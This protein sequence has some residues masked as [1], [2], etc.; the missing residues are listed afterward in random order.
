VVKELS[1]GVAKLAV[2]VKDSKGKPISVFVQVSK[3]DDED[4]TTVTDG[5]TSVDDPA[6]LELP[7]ATYDLTVREEGTGQQ[8]TIKG[9]DLAPG[10]K[11]VKELAFA[12]AKLGVVAKDSSGKSIS[13]NV[14]VTRMDGE[15]KKV[16]A[17]GWTN[18]DDPGFFELAPGTYD[19]SIRDEETGKAIELPAVVIAAGAKVVRE[20][21]F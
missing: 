16:V 5:W 9:V 10:A 11:V 17:D 14:E 13:V 3:S 1:F 12:T 6:F 19:V 7:P 20:V 2:V 15:E 4:H 8:T 21:S 18:I